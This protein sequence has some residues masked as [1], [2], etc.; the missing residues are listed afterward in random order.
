MVLGRCGGDAECDRNVTVRQTL[1]QQVEHLEFPW[2]EWV[3]GRLVD[4]CGRREDGS[5]AGIDVVRP[6]VQPASTAPTAA[7]P[8]RARPRRPAR[9]LVRCPILRCSP[10][11]G[12]GHRTEAP[13]ATLA[14]RLDADRWRRPPPHPVR[15]SPVDV[16]E[17]PD[18]SRHVHRRVVAERRLQPLADE[19]RRRHDDHRPLLH[20]PQSMTDQLTGSPGV[21]VRRLPRSPPCGR[22][23]AHDDRHLRTH[24]QAAERSLQSRRSTRPAHCPP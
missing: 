24:A 7:A 14:V 20:S 19:R 10:G 9:R 23:L 22:R 11:E 18:R 3:A 5:G 1:G 13:A 16:V 15:W 6:G 17:A 4:V 2:R 21:C 8:V 12:P